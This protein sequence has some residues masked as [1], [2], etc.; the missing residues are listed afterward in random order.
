ME[1]RL[2]PGE[3]STVGREETRLTAGKYVPVS[4]A[5]DDQRVGMV[6][7]IF[8]TVTG[9]YD[10]LN[11]LLSLRRDIMWRR[12]TVRKMRF[13]STHRLLDV[14]TGT[15]DLAIDAAL[16]YPDVSI[17]GLDFVKEMLDVG[18]RKI[19]NKGMKG[20][21][22]LMQGDALC[23]PFGDSTFDVAAVA[24]GI[25]NIPDRLGA[26]REMTRVVTADGQ[27]M[28]LEMS[29]TKNWF[30]TFMYRAYLNRILPLIAK[31]FSFNPAAYYYLA[32]S[33][34]NFPAPKEFAKIMESAGLIDVKTFKLTFGVTHLYVGVKRG[35]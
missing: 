5:T 25:R 23:M 13:F 35:Q 27:V 28:V 10:F 16:K 24:F 17:T 31:V 32:D 15:V 14:A 18:M 11:H 6:K 8:A 4:E 34:M 9:K 20:G 30:S 19:S 29:F 21:I 12:F 7:D 26:L 33:I 2:K 1:K 3:P 22:S